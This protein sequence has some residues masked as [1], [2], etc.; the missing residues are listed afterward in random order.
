MEHQSKKRKIQSFLPPSSSFEE[1][2]KDQLYF[3]DKS[4]IIP[5]LDENKYTIFCR[6]RRFGKS[7]ML[8]MLK[9]YYDKNKSD[10]FDEVSLLLVSFSCFLFLVSCFLFLVSCFLF[11]VSCFFFFFSFSFSFSF[12][13]PS[14]S[15]LLIRFLFSFFLFFFFSPQYQIIMLSSYLV[16]FGLDRR[17]MESIS[18]KPQNATKNFLFEVIR[19]L[20]W[21]V[22]IQFQT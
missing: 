12:S 3:A 4:T 6:P 22:Y 7:T 11:L 21:V 18:T 13:F 14:P 8:Q 19:I 10:K 1:N 16:P 5:E 2:R 9:C 20:A 17:K 15:C